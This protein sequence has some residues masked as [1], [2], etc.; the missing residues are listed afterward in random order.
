V[1]GPR[2][3]SDGRRQRLTS[4]AFNCLQKAAAERRGFSFSSLPTVWQLAGLADADADTASVVERG[5]G[6][7]VMVESAAP[8]AALE[9][10]Q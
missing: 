9:M 1:G 10:S 7:V 3:D 6:L 8:P 4:E 5:G 2:H